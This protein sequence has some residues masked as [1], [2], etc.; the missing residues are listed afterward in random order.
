MPNG[1]Q[2]KSVVIRKDYNASPCLFSCT[3]RPFVLRIGFLNFFC[4]SGY[5]SYF[6]IVYAVKTLLRGFVLSLIRKKK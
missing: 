3:E 6:L 4:C 1:T 5:N 2:K